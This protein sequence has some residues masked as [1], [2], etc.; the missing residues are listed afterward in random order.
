MCLWEWVPRYAVEQGRAEAIG[1]ACHHCHD[2]KRP[3]GRLGRG[4]GIKR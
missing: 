2:E 1:E 4:V 3:L